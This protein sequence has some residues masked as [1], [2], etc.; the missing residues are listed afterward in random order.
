MVVTSGNPHV[1]RFGPY[2]LDLQAHDLRKGG[3]RIKLQDQPFQILATLLER[4]GE[5]VSREELQKRLW[6]ADTFVD[7]DLS[8]NSAVKKL[9]Q[10][11]N[12]DAENPRYIETLYRRGYRFIGPLNDLAA[13]A[14]VGGNEIGSN[15]GDSRMPTP[16]E[17]ASTLIPTHGEPAAARLRSHHGRML[18]LLG[19]LAI[20]LAAS[21]FI[22]TLRRPIRI[23]GY[24]QITHD[25]RLKANMVTDGERLYMSEEDNEHFVIAQV[26]AKGGETSILSTPF[27]N[28]FIGDIAPD[29]SSLLVADFKSTSSVSGLWR[30]LLPSVTP[31]RMGNILPT[32]VAFSPDG[33]QLAYAANNSI[34]LANPDVDGSQK[35]T[36][37]K[38]MVS[39]LV[40]SPDGARIRFDLNNTN[41]ELSSLWEVRRNGADPKPVLPASDASL[42]DCCGKWTRDGR[43]FLFHRF[44]NGANNLWVL[45]ERRWW[46][47]G[48]R[49]AVQ[50]TNG[51]LAFSFPLPSPDGKKVYA[52]GSEPRAELVRFGGGQL[53]FVPYLVNTSATD[54]A[55][56]RDG[57]WIAYVSIPDHKLW[58]S[59]VD[60]S[61]PL[62][63]TPT[64]LFAG[65][66]RW[67]PDGKQIVFMARTYTSNY[68]AYLIS[69]NGGETEPLVP[70]AEAG[71][72][73]NWSP[74]GK[75]IV[76][77]LTDPESSASAGISIVEVASRTI[78]SV[79]GSTGYFSPR[80]SPDG[81]YILAISHDSLKLMLFD[82][83]TSRWS[84]LVGAEIGLKGYPTFSHDGQYLY[85]D[86]SFTV[87]S[88][89]YRLRLAD[90]KLERLFSLRDLRR[91]HADLGSWTGLTPDD[92][93][94]LVRDMSSQEV[95]A[96]DWEA[97]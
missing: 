62:Q 48:P 55:F 45:P 12:D 34:Y 65:L 95:Y 3:V 85:F 90:H 32:A 81:K 57:Q 87:D 33:K 66:P 16:G 1:V 78:S 91:F 43:Y 26:N 68:R 39:S 64:S 42:R 54:L 21:L 30:L 92:S 41:A 72:D 52:V 50:L 7:F 44:R 69:M 14:E 58:R 8:L 37:L 96:L 20:V 70:G 56:S 82:R 40:F 77:A 88:A 76:V 89:F 60:G 74:D 22:L 38:G 23:L 47:L 53:G 4:P 15:S 13:Q 51:P 84:E 36:T 75:T 28:V 5:V 24:T 18:F 17:A 94:L 2:E 79:P 35:L 19:G 61:Q 83:S 29:G 46:Q 63:L 49:V 27:P 73:P 59:R 71:F 11:L 93:P 9:R 10:A 67:S 6:P 25:G 80:Y 86:T 31:Q 97:P